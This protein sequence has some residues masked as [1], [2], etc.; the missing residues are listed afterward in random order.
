MGTEDS[1]SG[2]AAILAEWLRARSEGRVAAANR[3]VEQAHALAKRLRQYSEGRAEIEALFVHADDGIRL[4]AAYEALQW[5]PERAEPV[6]EAIRDSNGPESFNAGVTLEEWRA[7]RLDL[8]WG[9]NAIHQAADNPQL[10]D[11]VA[12][13]AVAL[14]GGLMHALEVEREKAGTTADLLRHLGLDDAANVLGISMEMTAPLASSEGAFDL[15]RLTGAEVRE[16]EQL[17]ER[18]GELTSSI[19][20]ESVF[21]AHQASIENES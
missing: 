18:Y 16:L 21:W 20:L 1:P 14:N 12:F 9:S 15:A 10:E 19:D 11:A 6:I 3:R 13:H 2:Y 5:A 7:G 17:D 4:S 8:D